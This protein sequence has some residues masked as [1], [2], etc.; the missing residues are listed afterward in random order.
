MRVEMDSRKTNE[1]LQRD[2][3]W[4]VVERIAASP[5]LKASL[6]LQEFLFYIAECAIREVPGDATEQQIGIHVFHRNPG[7][8]SSED[9]IVRTHARLLRQKLAA[10]FAKEGAQEEIVVDV[11]KGHYLPVFTVRSEQVQSATAPF[12]E[13]PVPTLQPA[14]AVLHEEPHPAIAPAVAS[15]LPGWRILGALLLLLT[16]I[17][18]LAF[19]PWKQA[20]GTQPPVA[21]S[22]VDIFWRPFFLGDPPFVVYSNALFTG[23]SISGLRYA[24][25]GG[26]DDQSSKDSYVDTYTGIGELSAVY[27]LTKLFDSH[28]ATFTLKRS[29]LVA[30][31]EAESRNLIFIG[32]SVENPSLRVLPP[33]V[34]F[35]QQAG[36]G[37]AGIVNHHPRP[38]EPA[39]Y[40]RPEH[41]LTTD[42]AIIALLPG[43][44]PGKRVLLFSG[45]TT[46]GTQAAVEFLCRPDSVAEIL[47]QVTGPKGE[48]Q[49]FEAVIQTTV[50]GGV[51]L[52]THLVTLRVD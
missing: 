8:N 42:Y 15:R 31:D 2:P 19:H 27:D 48:I 30:W 33:T 45:L 4:N 49:P 13:P 41:P 43:V 6:R 3:R 35:T 40:S 34:N 18:L 7:Y 12:E 46:F 47:K 26:A 16:A 37:F 52:E 39:M 17:T 25:P 9:S 29:Q 24:P 21:Q 36:S 38:G 20:R 32:A 22:P 51:A 44:Q 28:Q 23:N 10:Y 14:P 50:G 5:H 11:P 1:V